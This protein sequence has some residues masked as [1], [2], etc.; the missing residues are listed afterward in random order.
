MK[1]TK[2]K[3]KQP[4]KSAWPLGLKFLV[5]AILVA[6]ALLLAARC[7]ADTMQFGPTTFTATAD[8]FGPYGTRD[9]SVATVQLSGITGSAA[10]QLE[11]TVDGS[12]W[13]AV[14]LLK[15]NATSMSLSATANGLYQANVGGFRSVRVKA[16]YVVS[17]VARVLLSL[18]NGVANF[19]GTQAVTPVP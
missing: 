9:A 5:T 8:T 18:G 6:I 16:H 15:P 10:V 2:R 1:K 17:G 4:S 3:P 19:F 12:T 11:G 13:V 7:Q 14:M